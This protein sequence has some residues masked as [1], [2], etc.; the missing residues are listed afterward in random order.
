MSTNIKIPDIQASL[1]TRKIAINQVGIRSLKHPVL[2]EDVDVQ[3]MP[4]TQHAVATFNMYVSLPEHQKGTHMSRFL[5]LLNEKSTILSVKKMPGIVD[6]MLVR[7][8]AK[9][10]YV[11]SNFC[12]FLKKQAPVSKIESFL[13][14]EVTLKA[15]V[16]DDTIETGIELLVP[17]ATLCP[18]SKEIS[19]YGAHNQRS[20]IVLKGWFKETYP[21][22]PIIQM[23]ENEASCE[24]YGALK[25]VDEK[26]VTEKAYD[27]P[28]FVEDLV[29]D[30]AVRLNKEDIFKS[31][32]VSSENFESIHNHSAYAEIHYP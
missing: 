4:H 19:N 31:Y 20:H 16:T 27:N 24:L 5:T 18:C 1:D 9:K 25:R 17:A 3:G 26:W 10:A 12:Y 32:T 21:I 7:L 23:I 6:S 29:R 14:Y 8:E 30:I 11:E 15:Q 22:A 13:D 2:I 28:K